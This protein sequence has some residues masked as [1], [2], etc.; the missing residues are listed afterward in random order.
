M[1][2]TLLAITA[3]RSS[4]NSE[5]NVMVRASRHAYASSI[6]ASRKSCGSGS[7]IATLSACARIVLRFDQEIEWRAICRGTIR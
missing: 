4:R 7:I 1:V 6:C 3:V 5:L 2:V